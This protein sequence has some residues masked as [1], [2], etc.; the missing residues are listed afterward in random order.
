MGTRFP[1][2]DSKAE[3]LT[4]WIGREDMK[5][6][7]QMAVDSGLSRTGLTRMIIKKAVKQ[8]KGSGK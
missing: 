5:C 6:L 7:D 8:A 2:A 4:V 3:I 1:R